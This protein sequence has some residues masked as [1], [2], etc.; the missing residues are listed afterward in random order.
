MLKVIHR[1][2]RQPEEVRRHIL[3]VVTIIFAVILLSLW[4]YSLGTNFG[5]DE[6]GNNAANPFSAIKDNLI[7]GYESISEPSE[8]PGLQVDQ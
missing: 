8:A 4:V 2:R 1:L 6:A 5:S 7:G 3:H